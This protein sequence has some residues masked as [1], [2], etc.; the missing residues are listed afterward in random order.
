MMSRERRS[1]VMDTGRGTGTRLRTPGDRV[2]RAA[3]PRGSRPRGFLSARALLLAEDR[4]FEP[5]RALTQPAF[6]ASAIGH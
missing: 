6:Q 5:L 3:R 2:R 1:G 4:G